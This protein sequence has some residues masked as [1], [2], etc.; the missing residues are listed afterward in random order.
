MKAKGAGILEGD[1]IKPETLL[2]ACAEV[3]VIV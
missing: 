1:L 2:P 3:D